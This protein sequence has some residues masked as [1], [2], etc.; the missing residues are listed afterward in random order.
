MSW[1]C[2]FAGVIGWVSHR[3]CSLDWADG[4]GSP[5]SAACRVGLACSRQ[6]L[7]R[8]FL[9]ADA[10]QSAIS[11]RRWHA[12]LAY[13]SVKVN[14]MVLECPGYLKMHSPGPQDCSRTRL[15][16]NRDPFDLV[17]LHTDY[18]QDCHALG[19][20]GT[21][22]PVATRALCTFTTTTAPHTGQ[23][24]NLNRTATACDW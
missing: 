1:G 12:W 23:E 14:A 4:L 16:Q 18:P 17:C 21:N 5:S 11:G 15:Q 24:A 8:Q 10:L 13:S 9:V 3:V 2:G 20:P 19:W 6:H 7:W 22:S